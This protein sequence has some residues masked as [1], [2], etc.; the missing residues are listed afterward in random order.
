MTPQQLEYMFSGFCAVSGSPVRPNDYNRYLLNLGTVLGGSRIGYMHYCCWPCVCDTQDFIRVDTKNVITKEGIRQYHFAV[1]GNPCDHPEKLNEPFVQP[2][3]Y[4]ETTL[5]FEA[6]EVRCQDGKLIGATLSDHGY[7]IIS[8]F[9]NL[10]E[11][12]PT[13]MGQEHNASGTHAL[14]RTV[15]SQSRTDVPQPGRI[16]Q[17]SG[18]H[19][20]DEYEW[21]DYCSQRAAAG[22]NSGMG[23]I[24]RKVAAISPIRAQQKQVNEISSL[25]R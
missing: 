25:I 24:F 22:F 13:G 3:G 20:Q 11:Q 7:P 1:I 8:M 5:S 23:E 15:Q 6:R 9:F 2:F 21:K 14:A 16:L 4:R 17:V 10:S 12:N 18:V 19:V